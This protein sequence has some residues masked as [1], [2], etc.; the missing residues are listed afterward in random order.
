MSVGERELHVHNTFRRRPRRYTHI[1][2][3]TYI[4]T[5]IDVIHLGVIKVGVR[6]DEDLLWVET[7]KPPW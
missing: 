3:Y 2:V 4:Y 7:P 1:Y 6:A 5:Y